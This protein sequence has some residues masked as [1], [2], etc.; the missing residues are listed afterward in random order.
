[1]NEVK[2]EITKQL[3]YISEWNAKFIIF[4]PE[5]HIL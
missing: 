4:I 5:L 3:S 1:M 2:D